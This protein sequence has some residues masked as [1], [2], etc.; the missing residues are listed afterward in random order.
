MNTINELNIM[1]EYIDPHIIGLAKSWATTDISEAELGMRGYV[2]FMEDRIGR[3]GGGV[4]L[5]IKKSIQAEEIKIEKGAECEEA[6]WCN[7]FT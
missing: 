4:M 6:V 5:Y 2:M 7:I 3:R 1:V